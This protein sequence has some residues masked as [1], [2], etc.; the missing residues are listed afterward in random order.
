MIMLFTS[1]MF[2]RATPTYAWLKYINI[3]PDGSFFA[4][5]C[6]SSAGPTAIVYDAQLNQTFVVGVAQ[7]SQ[8][9]SGGPGGGPATEESAQ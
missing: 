6:G 2:L 8:C 3:A 7:P 9:A 1:F 5:S 4:I